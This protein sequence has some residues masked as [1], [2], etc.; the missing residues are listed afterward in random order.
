M[1]WDELVWHNTA[2]GHSWP[3]AGKPRPLAQLHRSTAWTKKRRGD[4]V[5]DDL[6]LPARAH[7]PP[8]GFDEVDIPCMATLRRRKDQ[9]RN[10]S[11]EAVIPIP[12]RSG[13]APQEASNS[14]SLGSEISANGSRRMQRLKAQAQAAACD[15]QPTRCSH[16]RQRD[17][18]RIGRQTAK[19]KR[20]A[21][22]PHP[23][24][25]ALGHTSRSSSAL[26]KSCLG[27]RCVSNGRWRGHWRKRG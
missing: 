9:H 8:L 15:D 6:H 22:S 16:P 24:P 19:A 12:F 17:P 18:S 13:D 4:T 26:K 27:A 21:T 23:L 7:C 14:P 2:L 10:T 25:C 1:I 20:D 3:G 11:D 5:G